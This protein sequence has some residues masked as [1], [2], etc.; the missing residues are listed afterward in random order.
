MVL[1]MASATIPE[2]WFGGEEMGYPA[3]YVAFRQKAMLFSVGM[4]MFGIVSI[5]SALK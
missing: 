3:L 2:A 1:G 4:I 5:S